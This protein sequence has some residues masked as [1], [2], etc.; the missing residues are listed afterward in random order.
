MTLIRRLAALLALAA[1]V[2]PGYAAQAAPKPTALCFLFVDHADDAVY[3][4]EASF[5]PAPVLDITG[6][7]IG[8]SRSDVTL[9]LRLMTTKVDPNDTYARYGLEWRAGFDVAG[10]HY[11]VQRVRTASS[12]PV[13]ADDATY[14]DAF[15]VDGVETNAPGLRVTQDATSITWTIPRAV[16]TKLTRPR[17]VLAGVHGMTTWLFGPSSSDSGPDGISK[18]LDFVDGQQSCPPPCPLVIDF[19]TDAQYVPEEDAQ[20]LD[21]TGADVVTGA[22]TLA[23]KLMLRTTQVG[24]ANPNQQETFTREQH[25]WLV[26]FT[27]GG[28]TYSFRRTR[29]GLEAPKPGT[30]VDELLAN[31]TVTPAP[32]LS[33]ALS[34]TTIT[35]TVPR[36][37]I[38]TL[39]PHAV[40]AGLKAQTSWTT[41]DRVV[42]TAESGPSTT[43]TDRAPS[44]DRT[45]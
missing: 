25:R 38:P 35:W 32:G 41:E 6:L 37:A 12:S 9:R 14:V 20:P 7:D 3:Q 5:G 24:P 13:G 10:V 18:P 34:P 31:G 40:I 11:G 26:S 23:V 8:T 36:S 39:K 33:V 30:Y 45:A 15:T 27:V 22:K 43:Y 16:I 19:L 42:D 21:V 4:Y 28:T 44:C 1:T 29:A 17:Q 2:L